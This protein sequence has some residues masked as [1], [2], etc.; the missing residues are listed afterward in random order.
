MG[1]PPRCPPGRARRRLAGSEAG[2]EHRFLTTVGAHAS[3]PLAGLE[4]LGA[5]LAYWQRRN[6]ISRLKCPSLRRWPAQRRQRLH[7]NWFSLLVATLSGRQRTMSMNEA[8]SN[9]MA[10]L[11]YVDGWP[12]HLANAA[13]SLRAITEAAVRGDS[14]SVFPLNLDLVV[15]LRSNAA[16][17]DAMSKATYI[18]A[19]GWPIASLARSQSPLVERTSG[20]DLVVP[21]VRE[22]ARLRLP[23]Y[24][25][26]TSPG[27]MGKVCRDLTE[28]F[29]YQLEIVGTDSPPSDFDLHGPDADAAIDRIAASG[30]KLCLLALGAPKD[31]IFAVRAIDRGV[32]AGFVAVGE[33][34]DFIVGAQTR[35][36][37]IMRDHG[38]EWLWRLL[39]NPRRLGWRYAQC[40]AV[41]IDL[42][43][44]S[45]IRR[46]F[47]FTAKR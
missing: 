37:S 27:V 16:L 4:S 24:L 13:K 28:R 36:P 8:V 22:A 15:R 45:P 32:K 5:V 30:A 44:L 41:L 46:R 25:F 17:R 23:V 14:F 42:L 31:E 19:E 9:G 21:I 18:L 2:R 38:L 7:T 40:A 47:H 34:L 43:L 20:A 6:W 11:A 3:D 10:P 26:G 33:G 12:I 29:D 39:M 35:A 1:T